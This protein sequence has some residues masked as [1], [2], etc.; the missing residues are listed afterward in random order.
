MNNISNVDLHEAIIRELA[1][2]LGEDVAA[3]KKRIEE[4]DDDLE[5]KSTQGQ[6]VASRIEVRVLDVED[7]IRPEDQKT[8]NLT[9]ISS[10]ERLIR[11]RIKER[12]AKEEQ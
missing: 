3:L 1:V 9:T 11:I 4:A 12:R 7:L 8:E 10:L 6:A 5:I 2:V